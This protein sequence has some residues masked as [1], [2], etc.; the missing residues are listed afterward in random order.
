MKDNIFSLMAIMLA[1]LFL[2]NPQEGVSSSPLTPPAWRQAV[3][4]RTWSF[5]RDH[6]AHPAYRTEWWYFTGNLRTAPGHRYGYQLTFFRQGLA[7]SPKNPATSWSIRDVYPAHFAISDIG[8][9]SFWFA[10]QVS[11]AG[12][13]LA[14][15]RT[16]GMDVWCLPWSARMAEGKILLGARKDGAEL[17]LE[18]TGRKPPALHGQK[19]LSKKGPGAGAASYYYS[20]TD[21][22][23]R[24]TLRTREAG[25]AVPVTGTSWFDHEFGSHQLSREQSGWDWFALHLADGRDLML[26]FLRKRDG[27]L[28]GAS[29]GTLVEKSGQYRHLRLSEVTCTVLATWR[30]PR[31]GARYP[32]RWRI[33]VPSAGID[34]TV[35]TLIAAQELDTTRST[36]V[37]YYEGAIDGQGRSAGRP[38]G[39]EGYVEMTGYAGSL[40]GVI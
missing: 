15:S 18:L 1:M 8:R 26:Y 19:G 24:G 30:S 37:I 2:I 25:A 38:V 35:A 36:G 27:A 11:R 21:L 29:S 22:A 32:N 12:P 20:L 6:G 14:G 17:N 23:T 7:L 31:S 5:P 3:A 13:G 4:P 39:C 40:G 9:N 10:E 16:G 28:E 34:L 33:V